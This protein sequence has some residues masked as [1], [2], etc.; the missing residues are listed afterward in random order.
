V[1]PARHGIDR[2]SALCL[3][4]IAASLAGAADAPRA[5]QLVSFPTEDGGTVSA[6]LYGDGA[7]GVVL[8]HGGRFDKGSW[9]K[10]AR[11]LAAAGFRVLAIDF[12]G[13]GSSR[14]GRA[15]T[16]QDDGYRHDVLAAVRFLAAR[17]ARSVSVVGGSL[18]GGAAAEAALTA[19]PGEIERLVLL[20]H[21]PIERPERIPGRKLFVICRHDPK[22]DGTPRLP[23]FREQFE[24]APEPKRL[25][26]LECAE[27]AQYV[28]ETELGDELLGT[29]VAFLSE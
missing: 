17:G 8:A 27:H 22:A 9:A 18:G 13:Y 10:Q 6:D 23:R 20:A 14:A 11:V 7:R 16:P 5:P 25:L 19:R 4:L 28:F 2:L 26:V 24:R 12:R 1:A 15:T 3:A 29:L 21:S